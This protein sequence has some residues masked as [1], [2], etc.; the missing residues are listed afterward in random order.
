MAL[1]LYLK[2]TVQIFN[3]CG[4]RHHSSTV[5]MQGVCMLEDLCAQDTIKCRTLTALD[6]TQ[7][8]SCS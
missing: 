1:L 7:V 6:V 4:Q 5:N 3:L 8:L 2:P